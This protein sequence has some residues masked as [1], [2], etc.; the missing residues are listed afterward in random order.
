MICGKAKPDRRGGASLQP[1]GIP[2]HPWK[3]V[4]IDYVIGLRSSG[5][6]GHTIVLIMVCQLTKMAHFVPCH[7]EITAKE[8]TNLLSSI[9]YRLHGV[10]KVIISDIDPKFVGKLC[11]S[12]MGKLITKLNMSIA[13]HPHT[14][15]LTERVNQTMQTPLKC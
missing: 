13:R 9:C 2:E 1:F 6:Y 14:N 7:T 4:G 12:F 3:T 8:S 15:G 11:Q 10:S 5:L